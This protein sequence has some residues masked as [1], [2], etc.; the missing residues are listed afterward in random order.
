MLRC[1]AVQLTR[2]LSACAA[3]SRMVSAAA[4]SS[5]LPCATAAAARPVFPA[6][7]STNGRCLSSSSS[8]APSSVVSITRLQDGRPLYSSAEA[9]QDP[10]RFTFSRYVR[11]PKAAVILGAPMALG[12]PQIGV[13]QG[14]T[15]IRSGGLE[16]RLLAD[17]WKV[18][19]KGDVDFSK[20]AELGARAAQAAQ[21]KGAAE[22]KD[23][24]NA[25]NSL[26]VG[27]ANFLVYQAAVA[28]AR[29]GKFVLTLGGD[30][31]I[32]VG[33]IAAVLKARPD[34]G[35]LWVDAHADINTPAA[36]S[37][38]NIHG[39]VLSF[40]M[41]LDGCRKTPGFEWLDREGIP[42]LDPARLVY[43]GLRDVDWAERQIIKS[44]NIKAFT[45]MDIDRLG[46]QTV[47]SHALDHLTLSGR[48]PR[49][50]HL[51]FDIDSIDPIYAP[52][53]GTRVSGGLTY[54]EAYF[55]CEVAA[56]S[57]LLA[58]MDLA[59]VN[60]Q[61]NVEGQDQTIGMAVGLCASAMGNKII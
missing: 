45:M 47:I 25:L 58:S 8:K 50:L 33:S 10:A 1:R 28:P 43:A 32:A 41:N 57:G 23:S 7:R 59:E 20:C 19:D 2:G 3:R 18:E 22:V 35:I 24:P 26:A 16:A 15:Y 38:K 34:A 60:P 13:D 44:L 6:Q 12:Q 52:S 5:L 61:I 46:M 39:M 55:L 31:S 53:T 54:R 56:E 11:S 27:Y 30:H 48:V 4:A 29:E 51:T 9:D 42:L 37:S 21:P 40:L 17:F 36:S 14:P 49:P